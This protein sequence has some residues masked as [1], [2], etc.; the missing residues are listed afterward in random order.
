METLGTLAGIIAVF[1][2][3]LTSDD[4]K[5]KYA[6]I[7]YVVVMGLLIFWALTIP[8]DGPGPDYDYRP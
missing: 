3:L 4:T 6:P 7:I 2:V 1:I 5:T 8:G